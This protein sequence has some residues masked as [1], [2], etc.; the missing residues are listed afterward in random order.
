MLKWAWYG[1]RPVREED[2]FLGNVA[3]IMRSGFN[4][5]TDS[6]VLVDY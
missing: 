6:E 1:C 5:H 4:R 3:A 2:D